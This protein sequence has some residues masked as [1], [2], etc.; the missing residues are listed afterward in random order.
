MMSDA[1]N[2]IEVDSGFQQVIVDPATSAVSIINAG[3]PG[4]PGIMGPPGPSGAASDS[5]EHVQSI[6]SSS[7]V[8][9]HNLGFKP[10]VTIFDISGALIEDAI[11]H[12]TINQVE[13]QFL[14]PR[15]GTARLS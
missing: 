7:W 1:S 4:P 9:N 5:H 8:I 13:L 2:V 12:K 15:V 3:P 10:N 14:T 6:Q 11:I